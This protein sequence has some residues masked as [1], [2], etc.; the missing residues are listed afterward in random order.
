MDAATA[1]GTLMATPEG[2]ADPYPLYEAIRA[3]GPV[4]LVGGGFVVATGYAECDRLLRDPRLRVHDTHW[5]DEAFPGWEAHPSMRGIGMSILETNAPDHERVR[6][7]MS[8]V[9][10]P[11]RLAR[12][13]EA[14]VRL[15]TD[16][17]EAMAD[18]GEVVDFMAEFAYLLPVNV[19]SEMLGIPEADRSWF[20]EIGNIL[21]VTV[22]PLEIDFEVTDAASLELNAYF[23]KLIA[24]RRATPREDL[25]SALVAVHDA[26]PRQLTASE[27][28]SNLTLL[29]LAGFE[30]TTNLLGNGLRTLLERPDALAA[31]RAEPER[32]PAYVEE[33]LRFDSP[34]QATSRFTPDEYAIGDVVAPPG[35][36]IN[37]LLGAANRDPRRFAR[38]EVFDPERDGNVPLSFG[39]GAHFCLG[40]ALARME[41]QIAFPLLLSRFPVIE[42][43]GD[44]VRKDRLT[45]RGYASQPVRLR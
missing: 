28:M 29:L 33:M 24:E 34:V 31:L 18:R 12:L 22:E 14:I 23:D 5:M 10:T 43:A 15:A 19:I 25:I 45:L 1:F 6:R 38:P 39:A 3:E 11:R 7:L 41:G 16:L 27:L 37:I 8:G 17:A 4:V 44:P 21:T 30:T 40:A 42:A 36:E 2:R 9:F 13:R 35:A 32:T 26:D 20:R